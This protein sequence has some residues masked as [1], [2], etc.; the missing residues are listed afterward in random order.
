MTIKCV[1]NQF[2]L[3]KISFL[4]FFLFIAVLLTEGRPAVAG[5]IFTCE[6]QFVESNGR[7]TAGHEI[8][9]VMTEL[10]FRVT[11]TNQFGQRYAGFDRTVSI[12]GR[13]ISIFVIPR[14]EY[15]FRAVDANKLNGHRS[16]V[17]DQ[18]VPVL[19][20]SFTSPANGAG[21][22]QVAS[23]T[24]ASVAALNAKIRLAVDKT[25]AAVKTFQTDSFEFTTPESSPFSVVDTDLQY[26]SGSDLNR[27]VIIRA[28]SNGRFLVFLENLV[29]A[30]S[31]SKN[32]FRASRASTS[33]TSPIDHRTEVVDG[34][35]YRE[36]KRNGFQTKR[37]TR[38]DDE[39]V[40]KELAV[41][42]RAGK[43]G[44]DAR[45]K[46]EDALRRIDAEVDSLAIN[47]GAYLTL[48][49]NGPEK[50]GTELFAL[51]RR[52]D[53]RALNAYMKTL[54]IGETA[55][56]GQI[57]RHR[58]IYFRQLRDH[59]DEHLL[60]V[61]RTFIEPELGFD[62]YM[63]AWEYR[64]NGVSSSFSRMPEQ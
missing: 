3:S 25:R 61:I 48:R 4:F 2:R 27:S 53:D 18:S 47:P 6:G 30:L 64:V 11:T 10:G 5:G 60:Q 26:R 32:E 17:V 37:Q 28:D 49:P 57:V 7:E 29:D 36:I 1:S 46:M 43:L 19:S 41:L 22:S 12:D 40:K 15:S 8:G 35:P 55:D 34:T 51:V 42:E 33:K 44:F 13:E 31:L 62:A 63:K 21:Q 54:K 50:F 58:I 52:L 23:F 20:I 16:W 14:L 45:M 56:V 59:G 39:V 38:R 9:A 24:P